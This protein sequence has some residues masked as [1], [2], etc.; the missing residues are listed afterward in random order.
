MAERLIPAERRKLILDL[1]QTNG[2][3]HV[4][5]LSAQLAVTEVTIRRDLEALENEHLLERT[6]GGAVISR[7][8]RVEPGYSQKHQLRMDEKRA[9]GMAAAGLVEA[10][11]TIF[12][13]SGST[14]L[15]I[16]PYLVGKN[17]RIIT[18]NAGV[19][20]MARSLDLDLIVVGGIYRKQSNS[21]VGPPAIHCIQEFYASKCFIGV[22]GVSR[23]FGLTTPS[24]D[25]AEIART[26]MAHTHGQVVV[27][28]DHSKLS[29]V[30]DCVTAPIHAVDVLIVDAGFDEEYRQE[31]EELGLKILIAPTSS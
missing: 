30:A 19:V 11:E 31:L 24:L 28:A 1:L 7:R 27:V 21:F 20:D 6:H 9:I 4:T 2:S 25:E 15:Q 16:F 14:N 29:Q 13:H 3:V 5:E 8:M 10:G 12:I 26:M 18:S 23:Q 17:V 22:D